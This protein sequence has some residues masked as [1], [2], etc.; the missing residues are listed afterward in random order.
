MPSSAP[1]RMVRGCFGWTAKPNT[2][3]S[4]HSPVRTCRQ[5]SPPSGLTQAPVPIVPAQIVKLS[6]MT[7]PPE[8]RLSGFRFPAGVRNVDHHIIG[9]GPFHLE[10]AVA[11]SSHLHPEPLFLFEAPTLGAIEL[12]RGL[13][14]VLDLKAEMMDAAVVRP[15]G[16]DIGGFLRL[17]I[18]DRQVDV[19]A[20]QEHGAVRGPPDLL[21]PEK[22]PLERGAP[23]GRLPRP[24]C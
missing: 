7:L 1:A 12:R 18:E 10:I 2:R 24:D 11:S 8:I 15:V 6:A 14:E 17:P 21:P 4:D 13:V 9:A 3:L 19:A 16:A 20:G 22:G 23:V 5:L